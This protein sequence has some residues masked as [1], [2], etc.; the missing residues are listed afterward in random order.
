MVRAFGDRR[1]PQFGTVLPHRGWDID[2]P[3]GAEVR[4]VFDGRVVWASWFRGYGL[5]VVIDHGDGVHSVYAHLSAI[6]VANG[7]EVS[8]GQVIGRVGDTGALGGPGLYLEI[9]RAGRAEDPANW[10]RRPGPG[11]S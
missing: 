4:A 3:H 1:E 9:R 11:R 10:I 6:V 7:A 8:R 5:L 2:A